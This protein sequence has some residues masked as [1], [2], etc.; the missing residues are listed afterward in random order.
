MGLTVGPSTSHPF[1]SSIAGAPLGSSIEG[2][3][4][5]CRAGGVGW[6]VSPYSAEVSRNW[7]SRNDANTTAQSASGCTGWFIPTLSQLQN[8]GYLCRSFWGPSPCF[9][10][11]LYRSSTYRF[12]PFSYG[13][14]FSN[15]LSC[16][17]VFNS[18]VACVRAFRCVTY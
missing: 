13:M 16:D 17:T 9:S 10:S 7:D 11:T 12:P 14:N 5:I 18:T 2:G 8:P 15:G 4:I 3:F 1:F 6:I